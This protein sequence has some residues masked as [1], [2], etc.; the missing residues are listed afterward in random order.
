M[1][2]NG[3]RDR[4][5]VRNAMPRRPSTVSRRHRGGVV[6][7]RYPCHAK[8]RIVEG[9]ASMAGSHGAAVKSA[10]NQ[11]RPVL[12]ERFAGIA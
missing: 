2:C 4:D 8:P 7:V 6:R 10:R 5:N 11:R 1:H 9:Y 12:Q 3:M